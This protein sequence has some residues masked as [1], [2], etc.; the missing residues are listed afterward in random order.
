MYHVHTPCILPPSPPQHPPTHPRPFRGSATQ[1]Q[2]DPCWLQPAFVC[3]GVCALMYTRHHC[4]CC[5]YVGLSSTALQ[6]QQ[7]LL[8]PPPPP[9]TCLLIYAVKETASKHGMVVVVW[10]MVT[11]AVHGNKRM[12]VCLLVQQADFSSLPYYHQHTAVQLMLRRHTNHTSTTT[13]DR[14]GGATQGSLV[15]SAD[16]A[17]WWSARTTT[18]AAQSPT[19]PHACNTHMVAVGQGPQQQYGVR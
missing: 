13:G 6:T 10:V 18:Q 17:R 9:R 3:Q 1:Q 5:G 4:V 2:R 16:G 14:Q 12:H 15:C 8:P 11:K 19:Q 7:L